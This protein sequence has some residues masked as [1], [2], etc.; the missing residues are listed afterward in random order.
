MI[1]NPYLREG[2]PVQPWMEPEL[3]PLNRMGL[4]SEI[5]NH[6]VKV[7]N[8]AEKSPLLREMVA[9]SDILTDGFWPMWTD[10]L[11]RLFI[12]SAF[13]IYLFLLSC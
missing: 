12:N 4:F 1:C 11:V 7:H 9:L 13:Q 2:S 6:Y 8:F 3:V 5:G 10:L